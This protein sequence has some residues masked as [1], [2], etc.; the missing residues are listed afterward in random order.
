[1]IPAVQRLVDR[2]LE[3]TAE[4]ARLEA[5]LNDINTKLEGAALVGE[6]VDLNDANREGKQFLARGSAKTVPVVISADS[7]VKSFADG[8]KTYANLQQ[9]AGLVKLRQFYQPKTVWE[10][11]FKSGKALRA[12][13]AETL[14]AAA[15]SFVTAATQRDKNGIPKN[16]ITVNWNRAADND[17]LPKE[18][19]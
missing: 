8:S 16:K 2:G 14:G 6:Q 17:A 10:A 9:I 5:E 4:M 7:I 11:V 1:M 18:G 15:P 19:A 13:A 12:I 3:I